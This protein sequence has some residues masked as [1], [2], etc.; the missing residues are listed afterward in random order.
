MERSRL[1]TVV[2][3]LLLSI[4]LLLGGN[5]LYTQYR[6]YH[7]P[8]HAV[9]EVSDYLLRQGITLSGRGLPNFN[10]NMGFAVYPG[11]EKKQ[12]ALATALLGDASRTEQGGGM[13]VYESASGTA[14]FRRGGLLEIAVSAEAAVPSDSAG[15]LQAAVELLRQ[16]G[17]AAPKGASAFGRQGEGVF[18][19]FYPRL[20]GLEVENAALEVFFSPGQTVISGCLLLGHPEERPAQ[21]RGI[22]SILADFAAISAEYALETKEITFVS[23][24]YY[25]T[26]DEEGQSLLLPACR[27]ETENKAFLLSAVDGTLLESR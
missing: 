16:A 13:T 23:Y 22:V 10:R 15:A 7:I 1:K 19:R 12:K 25:H 6:R 24:V 27:I 9:S 17:L 2:L 20:H 21:T 18:V 8:S 3:T 11:D 5:L 14:V 26:V 4:N